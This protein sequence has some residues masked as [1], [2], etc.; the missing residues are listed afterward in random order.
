M[1][2]M[3]VA[4]TYQKDESNS[5]QTGEPAMLSHP[6]QNP[7]FG[8]VPSGQVSAQ[9]LSLSLMDAVQRG[10]EHNL[11]VLLSEQGKK[12][13]Q[14]GRWQALSELLP[15]VKGS[16]SEASEKINLAAY[17]LTPPPP[18][19]PIVGPFSVF[20]ARIY[21]SQ[22]LLNLK[23]IYGEHAA[24]ELEKAAN[25]SYADA[26]DL[27]VLICSSLYLGAVAGSS[28]V[29]AAQS[30]V[31]TAQAL[32]DLS[33][34]LKKTGMIPGIDVL[35]SQVQLQ[36]QQQ[37]L[38]SLQNDLAREK[39][40]LA[41]AIGLPLGQEMILTDRVPYSK[42]PPMTLDQALGIAFDSRSDLKQADALVD[43]ADASE[44]AARANAYP[45][46][47][48]DAD[49]GAIGETPNSA[50]STFSV[51]ASLKIPIFQGGSTHAKVLQ[52]DAILQQRKHQRDDLRSRVE[53][54]VRT[55]LLDLNASSQ[56][57]E[58]AKSTLELANEQLAQARD[59]FAAGLTNNIEVLQAQDA[60]SLSNENY[61][62]S[63]YNYNLSKGALAKAT[64]IAEKS[65][66]QIILGEQ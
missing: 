18:A 2:S 11:G 43:A 56:N 63:V 42:L 61:I 62:A 64:G 66:R 32:F 34:D 49:Y 55:A 9:P 57:V 35:R 59:R 31:N 14:G 17:G 44:K 41:R 51:I 37:R 33:Q 45:S 16:L 36:T 60:V 46:L 65:F 21:V 27:V 50:A 6:G 52:A 4:Q 40:D 47:G 12:A 1:G 58:V 15:N 8:G 5:G 53:Y 22:S 24:S 3:A 20:D 30:Q 54:E 25:Y 28:R 23:H 29:E 38:T 48:V 13:A 10:L 26:R 7:F 19:S 39:L